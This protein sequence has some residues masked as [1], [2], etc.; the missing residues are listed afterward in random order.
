MNDHQITGSTSDGHHTFDELYEYRILYNAH[1]AHGWTAAGI[2]VVKSWRHSD[3]QECFGGGWFIVTA[4]LPTGQVANHYQATHWD[5]FNVPEAETAPEWDGH[6]PTEAADRLRDALLHRCRGM[7][8]QTPMTQERLEAIRA[9]LAGVGA[10]WKYAPTPAGDSEV[11]T[12]G[13]EGPIAWGIDIDSAAL[14]AHAPE[15]LT[16][17]LAEVERLRERLTVDDEM[18]RRANE[19][20]GQG[21]GYWE[22]S[23]LEGIYGEGMFL[24]AEALRAALGTQEEPA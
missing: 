3:G 8:E 18:I 4:D 14:I 15:D 5:L 10:I 24:T 22:S 16:D 23:S 19:A 21:L 9:R 6:T 2:P 13:Q 20:A 17:L 7:T 1:A 12:V 11:I